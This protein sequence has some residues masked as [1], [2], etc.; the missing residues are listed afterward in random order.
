V[1]AN[2]V[3][4]V[5][6]LG[7]VGLLTSL[8]S[9]GCS[10][11]PVASRTLQHLSPVYTVDRE[12]RSMKGP[13]SRQTVAFPEAGTRELL[14]VTGYRATMVGADGESPMS[15]AYMCH[16]NLN[17]DAKRHSELFGLPLYHSTRLFT[18]S[19]GQ[20]E[21]EFPQG[22][23]LPYFSDE[24]F[25]V[26][27]QVLN[28]NPDDQTHE[29]RHKVSIDYLRDRELEE[30]MKPLFMTSAWGLVRVDGEDGHFGVAEPNEAEHGEGCLPGAP[31]G[32]YAVSEDAFGRRFAGHWVVK[33]G[34]EVNHTLVTEIMKLPY[35]TTLHYVAVH[36]HPFAESLELVDLTTGDSVFK[37]R[38]KDFDGKIG[39]KRVDY[40]S[41]EEGIPLFKDHQYEL[42]SIYDNT[43][44]E[45][46]TS[47]AVMLLY[48]LDQ[49]FERVDH[50][51]A[52]G[53]P[54]TP[55]A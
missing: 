5:T 7:S 2:S 55:G 53:A 1:T 17:F 30:P 26:V 25:S 18:L 44:D 16:S 14:W 4:R 38:V 8:L 36:L 46:Q 35:D 52:S 43:T 28:L 23:G 40:F 22:F 29:V 47:M 42:I 45:D 13:Q 9:P 49:R 31:A 48:L 37:S 12:Y 32:I 24:T 34:R 20:Q 54:A 21:I 19:Q 3:A 41:S 39:I 50:A 11:A 33:P 15:Q 27:T 10:E 51:A 6:A